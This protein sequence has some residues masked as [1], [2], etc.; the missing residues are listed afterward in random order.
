M[1]LPTSARHAL[2][3]PGVEADG[4]LDAPTGDRRAMAVTPVVLQSPPIRPVLA[5]LMR[6]I[7]ISAVA[8]ES[9]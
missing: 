4:G 1:A 9:M 6:D 2:P 8:H 7:A 3:D 5:E